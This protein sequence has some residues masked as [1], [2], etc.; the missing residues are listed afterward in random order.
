MFQKRSN[1]VKTNVKATF[2]KRFCAGWVY[3]E[4]KKLIKTLT[5][6]KGRK[7]ISWYT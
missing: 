4:A 7:T 3:N 2:L 1:Y 5:I 6:E